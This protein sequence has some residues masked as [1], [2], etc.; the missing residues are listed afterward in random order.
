MAFDLSLSL[1]LSLCYVYINN[2]QNQKITMP[3]IVMYIIELTA[4]TATKVT[5][6]LCLPDVNVCA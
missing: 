3:A 6:T 5:T 4:H 1:S 2:F